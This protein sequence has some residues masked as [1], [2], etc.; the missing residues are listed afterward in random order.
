MKKC[1]A[2]ETTIQKFQTLTRGNWKN[3]VYVECKQCKY[4]PHEACGDFMYIPNEN[5]VPVILSVSDCTL[6]FSRIIDP[7]ECL[8]WIDHLKFQDIY[9]AWIVTNQKDP[10]QCPFFK[11]C[12]EN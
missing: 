12:F 4:E 3:S 6:L 7:S 11:F 1:F 8:L 10:F 5:G 9:Y 2:D